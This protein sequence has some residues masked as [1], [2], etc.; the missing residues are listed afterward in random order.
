MEDEWRR[1]DE[2]EIRNSFVEKKKMRKFVLE[3]VDIIHLSFN[4]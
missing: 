2:E 1:V 3:R 4:L